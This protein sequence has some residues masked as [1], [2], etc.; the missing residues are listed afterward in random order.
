MSCLRNARCIQ[1][2][3]TVVLPA[4]TEYISLVNTHRTKPEL[5]Q[6]FLELRASQR[7]NLL[8]LYPNSSSL[9]S[10]SATVVA[11]GCA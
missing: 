7:D 3:Q 6:H 4:T 8:Q 2:K 1:G 9:S 5:F 10:S 11:D